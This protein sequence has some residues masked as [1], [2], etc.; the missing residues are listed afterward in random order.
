MELSPVVKRFLSKIGKPSAC[1][2]LQA[3]KAAILESCGFDNSFWLKYPT[4][5]TSPEKGDEKKEEQATEGVRAQQSESRTCFHL[6][7]A[8]FFWGRV[9]CW[10]GGRAA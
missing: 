8:W 10:S 1:A 4:G 9:Y 5:Q 2:E 6:V 7:S 3:G